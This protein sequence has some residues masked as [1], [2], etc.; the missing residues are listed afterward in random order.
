MLLNTLFMFNCVI[1][2]DCL[3]DVLRSIIEITDWF[4][5]GLPIH[6][7]E[8]IK[9]NGNSVKDCQRRIVSMWLDTGNASWRNLDEALIDPLVNNVRIAKTIREQHPLER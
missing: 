5:L 9:I 1:A 6:E 3:V 8:N 4:S 2:D 7:L